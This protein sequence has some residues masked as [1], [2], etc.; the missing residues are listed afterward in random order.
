MSSMTYLSNNERNQRKNKKKKKKSYLSRDK[1]SSHVRIDFSHTTFFLTGT[2]IPSLL[3]SFCQ[4]DRFPF[5][6]LHPLSRSV[7]FNAI[8]PHVRGTKLRNRSM[9]HT[10]YIT[11]NGNQYTIDPSNITRD[12]RSH[13][14]NISS[15][16]LYHIIIIMLSMLSSYYIILF[17]ISLLYYIIVGFPIIRIN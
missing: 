5:I 16:L 12:R 4:H 10:V 3:H 2:S 1:S 13:S 6:Y 9:N 11:Q 8:W 14:T 15:L 7:A 17:Y